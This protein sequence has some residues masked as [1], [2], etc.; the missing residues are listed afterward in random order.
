MTIRYD[1]N[2]V[3]DIEL[4]NGERMKISEPRI[5]F[6][7]T[8]SA[9]DTPTEGRIILYDLKAETAEA[10]QTTARAVRMSGGYQQNLGLLFD[11]VVRRIE[12]ERDGLERQTRIVVGGQTIIP[13]GENENHRAVTVNSN[14]EEITL[15]AAVA[16]VVEQLGLELGDTSPLPDLTSAEFY[17]GGEDGTEVLTG[18]LR[19]HDVEWY[20]EKGVIQFS[21]KRARSNRAIDVTIS[22]ETGMVGT[23]RVEFDDDGGVSVGVKALLNPAIELGTTIKVESEII[24]GAFKV[25]ELKH[26]GDNWRRDHFNTEVEGV[27][28]DE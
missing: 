11:G 3:V 16:S 17:A 20:E 22:E 28:F 25:V 6:E 1:R 27:P 9:T 10:V 7:F 19:F 21:K 13:P 5:G 14:G 23:P 26:I 8:Y 12:H 4:E 24:T 15:K 2:L 18:W